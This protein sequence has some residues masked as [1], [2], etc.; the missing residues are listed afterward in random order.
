MKLNRAKKRKNN[1][2]FWHSRMTPVGVELAKLQE[3]DTKIQK[4]REREWE[5]KI[6]NKGGVL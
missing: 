1:I 3:R 5:E 6:I 4:W 2:M